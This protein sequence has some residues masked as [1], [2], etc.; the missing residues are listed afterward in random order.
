MVFRCGVK[1]L[2][3]KGFEEADLYWSQ[4]QVELIRLIGRENWLVK[5]L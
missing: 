3:L 1:L 2:I 5:Q 4:E